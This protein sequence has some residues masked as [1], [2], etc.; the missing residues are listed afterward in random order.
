[1]L[2]FDYNPGL[3]KEKIL[4]LATEQEIIEAFLPN[5]IDFKVPILSPF[6]EERSPSFTFKKMGNKIIFMD[7]GSGL[8]GDA[9][10]FV[11]RL[12]QCSFTE[13]LYLINKRLELGL[14]D[15]NIDIEIKPKELIINEK[16]VSKSTIIQIEK[17]IFTLTDYR[18]WKQYGISIRTLNKYNVKSCRNVWI[19]D[20]LSMTYSTASPIYAYAFT[21]EDYIRYK[22]Y[23]P[24]APKK[25]KWISN[26]TYKCIE[27]LDHLNTTGELLIVTKSLK[28]VM[29][30]RELGYDAISLH[31]EVNS[32]REDVHKQMSERF[33]HIIIFYDNDE[34]GIFNS[35]KIAKEKGLN[36][37]LIPD[38]FKVKDISD[39]IAT[40]GMQ[41]AKQ[42]L[43]KLI[44]NE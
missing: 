36:T 15:Q 42:L 8:K 27:G 10:T 1:M 30:L 43:I 41:K 12:H 37:I 38:K 26:I 22:V 23:R 18:Y 35:N 31:S 13:S 34:T 2:T 11:Q 25:Q 32:Y 29:C 28:D 9:F 17:Q 7:W 19:N 14:V 21:N 16:D 20:K 24:L 40:Y 5:K 3:S 6:R 33:K 44:H 4:S 39:F